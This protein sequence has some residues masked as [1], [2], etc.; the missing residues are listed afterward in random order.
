VAPVARAAKSEV[1]KLAPEKFTCAEVKVWLTADAVTETLAIA[2]A[3]ELAPIGAPGK[4]PFTVPLERITDAAAKTGEGTARNEV[5]PTDHTK[6][7]TVS[8]MLKNFL[9]CIDI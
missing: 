6:V 9:Y 5:I 7:A 1:A 4:F 8:V 3:L 2:V